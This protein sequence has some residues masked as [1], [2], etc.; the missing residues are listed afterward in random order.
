M[1]ARAH[2]QPVKENEGSM[3]Y[4]VWYDESTQKTATEK[5]GEAVAAYHV[6]FARAPLVVLVN[7]ADQAQVG[8]LL[9]RTEQTVQRNNFW[10]GV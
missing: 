2:A 8:D 1:P 3:D 10:L 6:R 4:F 9:I 7:S 5:I